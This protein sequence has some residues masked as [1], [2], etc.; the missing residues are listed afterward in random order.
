[1]RPGYYQSLSFLP[2][3]VERKKKKSFS[4]LA[5]VREWFYFKFAGEDAE[6]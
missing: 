3:S 6:A 4:P 1:M 5:F 2:I